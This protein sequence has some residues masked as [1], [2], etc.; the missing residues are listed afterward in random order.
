ME[1]PSI[2]NLPMFE[3]PKGLN[4]IKMAEIQMKEDSK[5]PLSRLTFC[6]TDLKYSKGSFSLIYFI[7]IDDARLLK[8]GG[9]AT[10]LKECLGFYTRMTKSM[11][12]GRYIPYY[13]MINLLEAHHTIS[14]Y[15]EVLEDAFRVVKDI[16]NPLV[17]ITQR[18]SGYKNREADWTNFYKKRAGLPF[19]NRQERAAKASESPF[20]RYCEEQYKQ[21]GCKQ[22]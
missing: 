5:D 15:G 1:F 11:G 20:I 9:A 8:I 4:I 7:V 19:L 16:E 12:R 18:V 10:P 22:R 2:E 17:E 21:D 3:V 13:T 6:L 14:F